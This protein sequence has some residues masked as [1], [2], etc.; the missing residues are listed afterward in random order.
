MN[1]L[2]TFIGFISGLVVGIIIAFL[3]PQFD[4][5]LCRNKHKVVLQGQY[6]DSLGNGIPDAFVF[7]EGIG[8]KDT[9]KADGSFIIPNI[10]TSISVYPSFF[11]R[12]LDCPSCSNE[13]TVRKIVFDKNDNG[14]EENTLWDNTEIIN[15]D[16]VNQTF[17]NEKYVE[18]EIK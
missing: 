14:Y 4:V 8:E 7:V 1:T 9:T 17:K 6:I 3:T 10:T 5:W 13:R 11:K 15:Q 2:N 18:K 16:T 12:I